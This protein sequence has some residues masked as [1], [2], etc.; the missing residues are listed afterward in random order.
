MNTTKNY[1]YIYDLLDLWRYFFM[2]EATTEARNNVVGS[3][4]FRTHE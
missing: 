2:L 4:T 3:V 1:E